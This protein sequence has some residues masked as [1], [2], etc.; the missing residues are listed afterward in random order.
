M[1]FPAPHDWRYLALVGLL[2]GS[3]TIAQEAADDTPLADV[4]QTETLRDPFWP[5]G[6]TPLPDS[7]D[8]VPVSPIDDTPPP[9][10]QAK[11]P[12]PNVQGVTR[13]PDGKYFAVVSNVGVVESGQEFTLRKGP[14]IYVFRV[15]A[16]TSR[17]V[18]Y[19]QL[20]IRP[21]R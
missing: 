9:M 12:Q 20:E 4:D 21:A 7:E 15:D 19:K 10:D 14:F 16:I 13:G 1:T 2:A 17:G 3:I 5:P 6:F 18:K 8:D 11:W